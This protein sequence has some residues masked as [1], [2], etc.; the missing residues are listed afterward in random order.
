VTGLPGLLRPSGRASSARERRPAGTPAS[1][2]HLTAKRLVL[3]A[4]T[5]FLTVNIWTGDPLLALWIGAQ[6]NGEKSLSMAAVGAVVLVLATL[7]FASLTALAWLNATYDELTGRPHV[8]RRAAWLRSM[9]A[10]E[11]GHVSQRV[12]VSALEQIVVVNVYLVVIAAVIWL[13][14]F[15][16][17]PFAEGVYRKARRRGGSV[18]QQPVREHRFDDEAA[19]DASAGM[20]EVDPVGSP[21]ME[22]E[23]LIGDR[24]LELVA[25]RDHGVD[26]D[27]VHPVAEF[28][29]EQPQR[30]IDRFI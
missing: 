20:V 24:F 16:G 8:E 14:F 13:V 11:R 6:V 29:G 5:A 4:A 9:R 12:G 10:E 18:R 2:P 17:S 3:A 27:Q 26:R 15:A 28:R 30:V 25:G 23:A 21:R 1:S 19:L 22:L 7:G